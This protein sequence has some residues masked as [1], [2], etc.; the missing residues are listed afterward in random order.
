[1]LGAI[2]E[3]VSGEKYADYLRSHI[4]KP[5]GMNATGY[6]DTVSNSEASRR[7]VRT[8]ARWLG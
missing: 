7:W 3:K 4:L 8:L 2:I 5:L 1:M 6:D